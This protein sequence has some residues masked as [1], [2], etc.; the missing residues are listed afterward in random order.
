MIAAVHRGFYSWQSPMTSR[1]VHRGVAFVI[2]ALGACASPSA[3]SPP[4]APAV[5]PSPLAFVFGSYALTIAIDSSCLNIP[6]ALRLRQDHVVIDK[7]YGHYAP[8]RVVSGG[9]EYRNGRIVGC[10]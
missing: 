5:L 7:G 8:V 1:L 3:P 9:F 4:P 2:A 6:P 10:G